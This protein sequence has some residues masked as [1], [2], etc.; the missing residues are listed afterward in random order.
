MGNGTNYSVAEGE[1]R[2]YKQARG[3]AWDGYNFK[4]NVLFHCVG[5]EEHNLGA[6]GWDHHIGFGDRQT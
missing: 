4:R 3:W 5:A 2:F 1:Q 6:T